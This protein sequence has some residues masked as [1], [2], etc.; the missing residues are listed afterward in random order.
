M[1]YL[2]GKNNNSYINQ[3]DFRLFERIQENLHDKKALAYV[4]L[5]AEIH[6]LSVDVI[7]RF[8]DPTYGD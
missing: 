8:I 5:R 3:H 2:R 4:L 7:R 1:P 6:G